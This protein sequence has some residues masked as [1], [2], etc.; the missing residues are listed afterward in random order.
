MRGWIAAAA[1]GVLVIV[2]PPVSAADPDGKV[3]EVRGPKLVLY[4]DPDLSKEVATKSRAEAEDIIKSADPVP[5]TAV[6]SNPKAWEIK[7]RSETYWVKKSQVRLERLIDYKVNCDQKLAGSS[8]GAS[9]GIG[10]SCK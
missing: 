4:G 10:G 8:L 2:A 7:V 3:I 6:A 1:F 5:A 9:R